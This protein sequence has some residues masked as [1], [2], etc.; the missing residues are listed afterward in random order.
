MYVGGSRFESVGT[1]SGDRIGIVHAN[2]YPAEPPRETIADRDRVFPGEGIAP[3]GG[4][5]RML[6]DSGYGGYLSLELFI[7]NFGGRT[8]PDTARYGLDCLRKAFSVDHIEG[9]RS[10]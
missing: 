1:L 7:E 10:T 5:A 3:L 9:A 4:L 6:C 8:A 2:D